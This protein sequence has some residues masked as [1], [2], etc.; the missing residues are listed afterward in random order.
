[1]VADHLDQ[2]SDC[3]TSPYTASMNMSPI[4]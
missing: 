3:L 4:A 1:V 2:R